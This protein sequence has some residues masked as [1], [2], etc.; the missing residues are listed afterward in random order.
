MADFRLLGLLLRMRYRLLW[1]HTR[2]RNGKI[3]LFITMYLAVACL[4]VLL[5]F[6]GVGAGVAAVRAGRAELV[7]RIV[8]SGVFV[9]GLVASVILGFGMDA[10]FSDQALRRYPLLP[11]ERLVTRQLCAILEPL[12]ALVAALYVGLAVGLAAFGAGSL[13][14]GLTAVLALTAINYLMARL[15]LN[16]VERLIQTSLGVGIVVTFIGIGSMLPVVAGPR[17]LIALA[18]LASM[19]QGTPPMLAATAMVGDEVA[20][21]MLLLAGWAAALLGALYGLERRPRKTTV[22]GRAVAE[23]DSPY[24]RVAAWFGAR[25][26]PM[27]GK[28]LRYY[29]R[30][31]RVRYN[32]VLAIPMLGFFTFTQARRAAPQ[33]MF[34]S[35]LSAFAAVGFVGVAVMAVNQFGYDAGGFRRYFLSPGEAGDAVRANSLVTLFLHLVLLPPSLLLWWL[36]APLPTTPQMWLMLATSAIGGALFFNAASI[37]TSLYSPRRTEFTSAFGNNMSLGGNVLVIGGILSV[38]FFPAVLRGAGRVDLVMRLWWIYPLFCLLAA[39]FYAASLK[40][41]PR[42]FLARRERLLALLEG[43]E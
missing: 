21:P 32:Y 8:L 19:A 35:A 22:V 4:V 41:A 28:A 38:M 42:Y 11:F 6:G 43:R 9:N 2:T 5:A 20:L 13:A 24:D 7:A 26:A 17:M 30:S 23:W 37:W 12:W 40:A 33:A 16:I 39:V 31:T 3:A 34:A 1:A 18:P 36:L 10:V 15:A 14:V 29:L 25:Y 27:A